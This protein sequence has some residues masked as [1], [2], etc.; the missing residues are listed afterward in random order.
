[1]PEWRSKWL[2][3]GVDAAEVGGTAGRGWEELGR[4][5]KP[6]IARVLLGNAAAF[7]ALGLLLKLLGAHPLF[8]IPAWIVALL[9][10]VPALFLLRS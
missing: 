4:M 2:K 9:N 3:E 1:M 10:L 5:N 6:L 7:F 8:W